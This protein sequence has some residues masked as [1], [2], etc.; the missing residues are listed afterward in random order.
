MKFVKVINCTQKEHV[1]GMQEG[2]KCEQKEMSLRKYL[3]EYKKEEFVKV[4]D[5]KKEQSKYK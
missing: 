2:E 1:K 3:T 4:K 5:D